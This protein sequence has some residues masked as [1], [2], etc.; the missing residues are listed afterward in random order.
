MGGVLEWGDKQG[1]S[2]SLDYVD[3]FSLMCA[4][5]RYKIAD[6]MIKAREL[7]DETDS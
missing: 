1:I 3:V 4:W 2:K 5:A 6:A 7:K